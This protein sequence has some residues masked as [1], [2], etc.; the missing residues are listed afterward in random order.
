MGGWSIAVR[1]WYFRF[2]IML[3]SPGELRAPER[4][5]NSD[6]RFFATI[7]PP[8]VEPELIHQMPGIGLD[9]MRF[10]CQNLTLLVNHSPINLASGGSSGTKTKCAGSCILLNL[11]ILLSSVLRAVKIQLD[12]RIEFKEQISFTLVS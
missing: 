10:V 2:S 3:L 9:E 7:K 12:D 1:T 4:S 11:F 6:P 5:P 8:P